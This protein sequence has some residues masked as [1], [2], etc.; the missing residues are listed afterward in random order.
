M[1]YQY[2]L[3]T[4]FKRKKKVHT[5]RTS[6]KFLT[7]NSVINLN[8][9]NAGIG[10]QYFYLKLST[11]Y[12]DLRKVGVCGTGSLCDVT[13]DAAING[14]FH[15]PIDA[16]CVFWVRLVT[17]CYYCLDDWGQYKLDMVNFDFNFIGSFT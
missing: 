2:Y 3:V 15:C 10:G 1:K 16:T 5:T 11:Q 8:F 12:I 9:K 7:L 17:P 4:K 6:S 14:Y 13:D